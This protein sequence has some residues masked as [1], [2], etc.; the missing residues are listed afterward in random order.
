MSVTNIIEKFEE[1][2]EMHLRKAFKG[3]QLLHHSIATVC[4][5]ISQKAI[6]AKQAIFTLQPNF[7]FFTFVGNDEQYACLR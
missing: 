5:R 3:A 6:Y 2:L 4:M 7:S 1:I